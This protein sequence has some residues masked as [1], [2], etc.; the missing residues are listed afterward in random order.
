MSRKTDPETE[1]VTKVYF[2]LQAASPGVKTESSTL[3]DSSK[4]APA[5]ETVDDGVRTLRSGSQHLRVSNDHSEPNT[6][7]TN[8]ASSC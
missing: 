6:K 8:S 3:E 2:D 5:E 7:P 4:P 1:R